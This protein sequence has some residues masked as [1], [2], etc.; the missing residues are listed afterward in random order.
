[1]VDLA[2]GGSGAAPPMMVDT[3]FTT[4]VLRL[5][6]NASVRP[7]KDRIIFAR[8]TLRLDINTP[9]IC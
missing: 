1:M 8:L 5:L 2:R 4:P 6:Y 7:A 9:A 3:K